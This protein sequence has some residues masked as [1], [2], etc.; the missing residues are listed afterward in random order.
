M[1]HVTE[2]DTTRS[3]QPVEG[4]S[5]TRDLRFA[6]G[7]SAGL[8]SAILVGGALLAPVADWGG[9]PSVRDRSET[10][11]VHLPEAPRTGSPQTGG[12]PT[13][14]GPSLVPGAG[15]PVAVAPI[16][17]T[18]AAPGS[19]LPG[20]TG[21]TGDGAAGGRDGDDGSAPGRRS[22]STAVD[23]SQIDDGQISWFIIALA[24]LVL[25]IACANLANLQFART[26]A[27]APSD[28][29]VARGRRTRPRRAAPTTSR[30]PPGSGAASRP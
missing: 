5:H 27:R 18:S 13:S 15:G 6:G 28:G 2:Q 3:A 4:G 14:S 8:V 29:P 30:P 10:V 12:T 17:L 25:L 16:E 23:G 11:T 24:G 20:V 1:S 7:V 9:Q 21:G 22:G 19:V 26:A